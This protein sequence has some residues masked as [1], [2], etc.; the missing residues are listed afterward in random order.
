MPERQ[1]VHTILVLSNSERN[2]VTNPRQ[3]GSPNPAIL[4]RGP[5]HQLGRVL[6]SVEELVEILVERQ[7]RLVA[8][9]QPPVTGSTDLLGG[10]LGDAKLGDGSPAPTQ[11]FHEGSGIDGL[12]TI[13]SFQPATHQR[14]LFLAE[15]HRHVSMLRFGTPLHDLVD[16]DVLLVG[17]ERAGGLEN[18]RQWLGHE[19]ILACGSRHQLTAVAALPAPGRFRIAEIRTKRCNGAARR[20]TKLNPYPWQVGI[21]L[22]V[23]GF[24]PD[25]PALPRTEAIPWLNGQ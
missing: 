20:M 24:P 1:D 22:S 21:T 4:F 6:Q 15:P 14:E 17:G 23:S 11:L 13:G 2:V 7:W 18:L 19:V 8:I 9:P 10:V 16:Q 25:G 5:T 12:A 3:V